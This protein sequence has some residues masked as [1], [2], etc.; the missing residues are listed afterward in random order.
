[1]ASN[2]EAIYLASPVWLQNLLITGMGYRLFQKRYTGL[3][4]DLLQQAR[5]AREW[6]PAQRETWQNQQLHRMV[7]H[8]RNAIPYYQRLFA[9]HGL[10]END[11]TALSDL[12]KI[13]PLDKQTVRENAEELRHG[14]EKPWL[15][16]HTSGS[17]GTPLALGVNE[18]TYKLAMA[19]VVDHEESHGVPF[20]ARRATFAG[21]MVQPP[22][23][24][25]PPFARY[26]RAENQRLYSAY[27]LNDQTFDWYRRDLDRFQPRELIG[28]P[29]AISELASCYLRSAT[30]PKFQPKAI[31]TNSE[32]L[33]DWQ[34][35]KI[36]SVFN[37]PVFDYY[38]TAEYLVFAGQDQSGLYRT[39]PLLGIAEVCTSEQQPDSGPILATTLTN[40][41]MPLLRYR[42]GDT[43]TLESPRAP[44]SG[45]VSILKAINGREDDY[46]QT[47][48]GR[49]L[50]RMDHIFKGVRGIREAQIIQT[51]PDRCT[52]KLVPEG[53]LEPSDS[54]TI[55]ANFRKRVADA[56]VLTIEPVESIPRGRNGK[57]KNVIGV[58]GIDHGY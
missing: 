54:D 28:Y 8:C 30:E 16:Q 1:M 47:P 20:G 55:R 17:T 5:D 11:I 26:N 38:G 31:V 53:L 36:E 32:T 50:G 49:R 10:H 3:Y 35:E 33:L 40:T 45:P 9:E 46:I 4:H 58:D 25:S 41:C 7:R 57:F 29:S 23:N 48:D 13:P 56:M 19:L 52:V 15:V 34:R 37:C 43:A 27:H 21:R 39:N 42:I 44:G 18:H 51:A 24:M 12:H 2:A 6:T 14:G 22:D